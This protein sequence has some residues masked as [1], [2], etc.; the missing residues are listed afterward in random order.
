MFCNSL[1]HIFPEK[2]MKCFQ[3]MNMLKSGVSC[4]H[5]MTVIPL[6]I[7]LIKSN[8]QGREIIIQLLSGYK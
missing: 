8:R 3:K 7:A 5:N 6:Y 1:L 2:E 4:Y